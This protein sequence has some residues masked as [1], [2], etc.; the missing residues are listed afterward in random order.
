VASRDAISTERVK[1]ALSGLHATFVRQV[2]DRWAASH[3]RPVWIAALL[4][5]ELFVLST[6]LIPTRCIEVMSYSICLIPSLIGLRAGLFLAVFGLIILSRSNIR[7]LL[8]RDDGQINF[9]WLW[10][11][12]F[13]FCLILLPRTLG[14]RYEAA[15]NPA[16]IF[17]AVG[18]CLAVSGA[19]FALASPRRWRA[20]IIEL[21]PVSLTL[22]A[23]SLFLPEINSVSENLWNFQPLT[24]VTFQSVV[25]VLKIFGVE[26]TSRSTDYVLSSS[27][28]SIR[29]YPS[30]SGVE[31]FALI[32]LFFACYFYAFREHLRFPNAWVLL[33]IGLFLS[34]ALNVARIAGLFFI[35]MKGNPELA[36]GGFHSHAGWLTFS[37]LSFAIIGVSTSVPWFRRGNTAPLS[38][39]EDWTAAR[40][41]PFAAFM[42][43]ALLI[44]TFTVTP[45]LWYFA[46]AVAISSVLAT[47]LPLYR[48]RLVWRID[49][50]A[51]VVGVAI[52]LLWIAFGF[53]DQSRTFAIDNA[54]ASLPLSLWLGWVLVRLIGTIALV[55]VAEE[56]FFR[57]YLLDRFAHN[58]EATR[59]IGLFLST[60]LFALMHGRWVLAGC[61]GLVYGLLYLRSS[62][63][64]DS[65]V[66]HSASNAIIGLYA[67]ATA[68][69]S[70]I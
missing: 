20:I 21:G 36:V 57:G 56:L 38:L 27:S 41:L 48:A 70:L 35:G 13:G 65:I 54:L 45:D 47:Y 55:P 53:Q 32:T 26:A 52:G 37:A 30:C 63:L 61:A 15:I 28:F 6:P 2:P 29:V 8:C 10:V 39:W 50:F 60:V 49:T 59:V 33:P 17:W 42:G 23:V 12:F 11:Q 19:A 24:E 58:G 64:T 67:L 34:W 18:G 5:V 68:Q 14:F 62:R 44:S 9:G 69:W 40:I 7:A 16:L 4:A 46:K 43:A 1:L 3:L 31:G 22:L 66:A 51:V 25:A